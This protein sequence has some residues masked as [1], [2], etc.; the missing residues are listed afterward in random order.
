M[1]HYRADHKSDR[2]IPRHGR[3]D[4]IE[5]SLCKDLLVFELDIVDVAIP[6]AGTV[7]SPDSAFR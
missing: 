4:S 3:C 1:L 5:P 6:V 7:E 2:A